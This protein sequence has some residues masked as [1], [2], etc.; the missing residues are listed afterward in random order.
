VATLTQLYT[1]II[2]DT[3]RDDM[4]S[5]GELEQAKIDAVARAVETWADEQF[6]FNRKSGTVTTTAS[7]A[8]SAQPTGMRVPLVVSYLGSALSKVPLET[9]EQSYNAAS[10]A[11]GIPS[12]WAEDGGT[13]HWYPTPDAAYALST[14]GLADLGVPASGSSNAWTAEAYDLILTEAK[15]ILCRGPLR[16]P[17]GLALAK[18]GRDEA[19]AH[20]RR[21]TRRRGMAPL[22]SDLPVP[23]TFNITR[24]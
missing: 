11:T 20:L 13:I 17:D 16:D 19:L 6:W 22:T 1:A 10:P 15:I 23:T 18:D 2:L 9:I 14:Y 4:G 8:T 12:S 24:G 7:T 5:G 3:N 21:E